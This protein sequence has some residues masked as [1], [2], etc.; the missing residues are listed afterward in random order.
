MTDITGT[1]QREET[2]GLIARAWENAAEGEPITITQPNDRG[3]KSLEKTIKTYF[4]DAITDSRNKARIITIIKTPDTPAIITEWSHHTKLRL[5]T[6]TGFY[7][8]P[9]LFGWDRIDVGSKLLLEN[10]PALKG[11][12]ADF[13]CGYGFLSR[14]VLNDN[15]GISA[16]YCIDYDP[17][18]V[19]ACRKNVADDRAVFMVADCTGKIRDLPKLD[20]IIM[21]PPFH[22]T[23]S[24]DHTIGQKFIMTAA[25]YL[26]PNGQLYMVANRHLPYEK[27]LTEY[28]RTYAKNAD[29][30]G[31]K[32]ITA[33]R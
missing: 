26:K 6:D 11:N 1:K 33:T 24:E 13:G 25:Q 29:K 21:N 16:L 27:I 4:P 23:E 30:N 22:D 3:G 18:A 8:L 32:V 15:H 5:V 12:G 9:G 20:F 10:L 7:S 14:N 28:F 2:F 17:R 19:E 31:F